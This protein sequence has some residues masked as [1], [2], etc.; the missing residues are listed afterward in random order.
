MNVKHLITIKTKV[1]NKNKLLVKLYKNK[2]NIYNIYEKNNYLYLEVS[3]NDYKEIKKKIVTY[4]FK[5]VKDNGIFHILNIITPL[6]VISI[7]LFIVLISIFKNIIID[8][9]VIHSSKEIRSIVSNDL[10]EYGITIG[11]FKK[12]F[13]ELESIKEQIINNHK[14]KIE[15]LEIEN[16]GM[17]YIVRIEERIINKEES[18]EEYCN[19]VA[20]KSGLIESI[21]STKGD[22]LVR[23]GQYV[24]KG[25]ILITGAITYNEEVKQNVCASGSVLAEV[26][27]Q[28][29]VSMPLNYQSSTRTGKM[30]YNLL[31]KTT[32]NKY[33]IFKSRLNNYETEEV[34]L[35]TIFNITFYKLKEYEVNIDNLKY[36]EE[37][38]IKVA[39]NLADEKIKMKL[40]E[41][42]S[43]KDRKVLK[44]SINNSKIDLELF[45]VV[46]ED[47]GKKENYT[48]T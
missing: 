28:T 6:K 24:N 5:K 46:I 35:F 41:N 42:E 12:S 11:S 10:E 38:A 30:R 39:T 43:I 9:D 2:I 29:S 34:K 14:D 31:I 16:V 13:K 22:V 7:V 37:E 21:V 40:E 19:L 23:N 47:I 36:S 26:W 8:I 3:A 15:W 18:K 44:K 17:K 45:Y 1:R 4:K 27:Y 25:D 33:K 32:K 20:R 48:I